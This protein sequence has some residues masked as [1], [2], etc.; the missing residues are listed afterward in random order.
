MVG[1]RNNSEPEVPKFF[2][3]LRLNESYTRDK[4]IPSTKY[5]LVQ[6]NHQADQ[7]QRL[8]YPD[9]YTSLQIVAPINIYD[10]SRSLASYLPKGERLPGIYWVR[11]NG[12]LYERT[13]YKH[14]GAEGNKYADHYFIY[15]PAFLQ[16]RETPSN[17]KCIQDLSVNFFSSKDV[18]KTNFDVLTKQ[19]AAIS[20]AKE[21]W[22]RSRNLSIFEK[23]IEYTFAN[24]FG[25][26]HEVM[27][28]LIFITIV[29]IKNK[30]T[31]RKD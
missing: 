6:G 1:I 24:G 8:A 21:I 25:G 17:P 20:E 2:I 26:I 7:D 29:Y 14:V 18:D 28:I 19:L 10:T 22:L 15:E 12:T 31:N 23:F 5:Y 3:I 11:I 9:T 27:F 13:F 30:L 16:L 4:S